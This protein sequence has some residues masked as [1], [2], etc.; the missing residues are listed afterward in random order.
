MRGL[1]CSSFVCAGAGLASF[2]AACSGSVKSGDGFAD[3]G[4][5]ETGSI[6]ASA[7]GAAD[8]KSPTDAGIS[9]HLDGSGGAGSSGGGSTATSGKIDL[10]IDID[11]SASMGDKQDYLKAAI[12]DLIDSLV[13]PSCVD[14]T[15]RAYV[16]ASVN[17]AC[18]TG[19]LEYAPVHDMHIALITSSLGPRGGNACGPTAFALAPFGNVSAHNDDQAHLINRSLTYAAGGGS[20]TE[21][22]VPDA[23]PAPRDE[24]L[25]WYPSAAGD[26]G[27]DAGTGTPIASAQRIET[28][29][30]ELVGGAGVFGCGIESQLE[31]WYR[32]LV[33]PDPYASI[34]TMTD[35]FGTLHGGWS[36]IDTTVLQQRHD[37]LR[38]DSLVSI[39]VLSDENDSEVDVRALGG[40]GVNWLSTSF[41]P[42]NGTSACATNPGS[43]ACQSC[44]QGNNSATDSQCM[45]K[46]NYTG[47]N[48]WGYDLNLRHVHM[49][50]KY[51]VDVQF[52]IGRYL[53]GLT[54]TTVPDRS[55]EYPAA[56]AGVDASAA[57]PSGYVGEANCTN[58]LFAASLPDPSALGVTGDAGASIDPAMLC[59]LAVG[60]RPAGWVFYTHIGGVPSSLL[61]Y[62]PGNVSASSLTDADWTKI[63]GR[64]PQNY[65]YTGIDPHMIES[66][67]PRSGVAPPGSANNADPANGHDWITDQPVGVQGGHIL[68]V[69]RQ[70]ACTFPLIDS[71]GAVVTRDCTLAQNANFCDCPHLA[72]TLTAAQLPPICDQTTT[73]RQIGAK[74]Y[75]TIRELLLAKLLGTQGI[76]ASIC[77]QHVQEAM[78]GDPLWGYRP[79]LG[80][81]ITRLAPV[82]TRPPQ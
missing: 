60:S 45:A 52:P 34:V 26:A 55:G 35:T 53:T 56:D 61:H 42:P 6:E 27:T 1:A 29:L 13:N 24:F 38:P 75:P 11:N 15:T 43:A 65:D 14:A 4:G 78:P 8:G 21:G 81:L 37:F 41:D 33:Q 12:P 30:A 59:N 28:D 72:G 76:V 39:I 54:S 82:I 66:Y 57:S 22:V 63:L 44:A 80:T 74:A 69:D 58:P 49:K 67:Q 64:D 77:P 50:A 62:T 36:G 32:F 7:E 3:S 70:Y 23:T 5:P 51:G 40:L 2:L 46:P 79:A 17:G 9:L 20:V 73:T 48:D 10:L 47:I 18:S 71:T 31:S 19:V 68:Q 16:G 25:F